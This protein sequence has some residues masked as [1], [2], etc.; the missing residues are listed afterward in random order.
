MLATVLP[1]ACAFVA[2][3]P[4]NPRALPAPEYA[5]E[6]KRVVAELADGAELQVYAACDYDDGAKRAGE[7]AG[8]DGIICAFGSLYSIHQAKEAF[9]AAG[10]IE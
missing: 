2:V 6:A 7:Y 4:D 8:T 10:L 3:T 9:R 5:A 1:Y